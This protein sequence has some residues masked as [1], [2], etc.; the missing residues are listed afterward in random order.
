[1]RSGERFVRTFRGECL[2][3]LLILGHRH[4]GQA[5]RRECERV[6][7]RPGAAGAGGARTPELERA[8]MS[9]AS[10]DLE[11]EYVVELGES[12]ERLLDVAD[13]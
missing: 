5:R 13:Q 1:M 7:V 4:L 10:R 12:P 6:D 3:L 11:T 8:R 2:D 9:L